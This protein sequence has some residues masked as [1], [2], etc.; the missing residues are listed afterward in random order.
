MFTRGSK[1]SQKE[2]KN[3]NNNKKPQQYTTQKDQNFGSHFKEYNQ[4]KGVGGR[5]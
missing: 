1:N 5:M 2:K 4:E 3:P